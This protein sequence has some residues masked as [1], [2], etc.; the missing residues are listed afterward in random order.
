MIS[1]NSHDHLFSPHIMDVK[2]GSRAHLRSQSWFREQRGG[3]ERLSAV[4]GTVFCVESENTA[5]FT[6]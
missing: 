3:I 6:W 1:R 2:I 4:L 5:S